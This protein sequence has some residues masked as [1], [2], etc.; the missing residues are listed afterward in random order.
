MEAEKPRMS[1]S[2]NRSLP[3]IE[4]SIAGMFSR[5]ETLDMI[6]A[7]QNGLI[8]NRLSRSQ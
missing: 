1:S 2:K 5:R 4:D 3:Q 6:S 7:V 8:F